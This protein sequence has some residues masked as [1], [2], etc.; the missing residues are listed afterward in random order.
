LLC[1]HGFIVDNFLVAFGGADEADGDTNKDQE[2]GTHGNHGNHPD[3][4]FI[5]IRLVVD[6]DFVIAGGGQN[7]WELVGHP[8]GQFKE[9]GNVASSL[10]GV[11]TRCRTIGQLTEKDVDLE[12]RFQLDAFVD[13]HLD[14]FA[15]LGAL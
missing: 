4:E 14:A 10:N 2:K 8:G 5:I 15:A 6:A 7:R 11:A 9:T 13:L 3:I 1:G 12:V